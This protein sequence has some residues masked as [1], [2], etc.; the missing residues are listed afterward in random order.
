MSDFDFTKGM[1]SC[2]MPGTLQQYRAV[3]DKWL[4]RMPDNLTF[5]EAATVPTAG[6]SAYN[7]VFY[8]GFWGGKVED[9]RGK[10]V[11]TQGSGGVS[12]FAI[13][14]AKAAGARVIS[15][16]SST[17][18]LEALKRIGATDLINYRELPDWGREALKMTGGKGVDLVVD[19][20][21]SGTIEQSVLATRQGGTVVVV[22]RMTRTKQMDL[23]PAILNQAKTGEFPTEHVVIVSLLI[24]FPNSARLFSFQQ[25]HA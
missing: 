11:L 5:A 25:S 19:V 17:E 14:L 3:E 7:G 12:C 9:L 21:G 16:S 8:Q 13:Q 4:C 2:E 1:G 23:I 6:G 18:K 15:T 22:G 10:T 24:C 20:A